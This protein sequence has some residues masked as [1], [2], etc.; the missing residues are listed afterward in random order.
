MALVPGEEDAYT[1]VPFIRSWAQSPERWTEVM[2]ACKTLDAVCKLVATPV[3]WVAL[4][5]LSSLFTRSRFHQDPET[6]TTAL[7]WCEKKPY[8]AT[9]ASAISE[10]NMDDAVALQRGFE[11]LI[12]LL[13]DWARMQS[14][15][16]TEDHRISLR[17]LKVAV[18]DCFLL[19][20]AAVLAK[21]RRSDDPVDPCQLEV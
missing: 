13:H 12:S 4:A 1:L 14:D 5:I 7:M 18:R 16:L 3:N 21:H 2:D 9:V 11:N 8:P 10:M 20:R 17:T 6:R 15:L 19:I